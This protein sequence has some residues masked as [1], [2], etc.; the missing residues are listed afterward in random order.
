MSLDFYHAMT[1]LQT[2]AELIFGVGAAAHAYVAEWRTKLRDEIGAVTGLLHS[3]RRYRKLGTWTAQAR[4]ALT[5]EITYFRRQQAQMHYAEFAWAG[6]PMGSGVTE[7]GCK[8]LIKA[9]FCR[10]GMRWKRATGAPLLQLRALKLSQ[11]WKGFWLHV[12]QAT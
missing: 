1:H 5:R 3:L 12:M 2:A 8:E 11:Q 6:L 4:Q 9:R 10:S 7:A